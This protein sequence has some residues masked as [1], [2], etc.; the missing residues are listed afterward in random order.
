MKLSTECKRCNGSGYVGNG[1]ETCPDCKGSGKVTTWTGCF[2]QLIV[3]V[4]ILIVLLI[5]MVVL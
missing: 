2:V 5:A 3:L 4:I 1:T